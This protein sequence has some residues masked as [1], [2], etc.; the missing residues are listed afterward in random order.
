[1][2]EQTTLTPPAQNNYELIKDELFWIRKE[3]QDIS[4]QIEEIMG[5][6]FDHSELMG[7]L[8]REIEKWVGV[9]EE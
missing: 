5:D 1:M 6:I 3:L 4:T 8:A 2:T 9:A 7:Y